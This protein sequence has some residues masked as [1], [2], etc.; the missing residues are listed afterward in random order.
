[1]DEV[2]TRIKVERYTM[3]IHV[4]VVLGS[5]STAG[6][7]DWTRCTFKPERLIANAPCEGMFEIESATVD[8]VDVMCTE[9]GEERFPSRDA[10][11]FLYDSTG[12]TID[13][14]VCEHGVGMRVRYTGKLPDRKNADGTPVYAAGQKFFF[15]LSFTGTARK[16]S[17]E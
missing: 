2:V 10:Y 5:P 16:Q 6:V 13:A 3:G 9:Q 1:M 8:E 7:S 12:R 14:P 11:F 15:I 4:E 17:K